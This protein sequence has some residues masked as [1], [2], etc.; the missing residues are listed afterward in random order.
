M[1]WQ[2]KI[3]DG[4]GNCFRMS[5]FPG[6]WYQ[7]SLNL[8]AV[9]GVLHGMVRDSRPPKWVDV[10]WMPTIF[11]VRLID[12]DVDAMMGLDP[13]TMVHEVVARTHLRS[14][15]G[16]ENGDVVN[17]EVADNLLLGDGHTLG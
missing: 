7:G 11:P 15:F 17:V 3:E 4:Q 12:L 14:Q 16:L 5:L 10:Q 9:D 8:R 2:G 1:I 13:I 6:G